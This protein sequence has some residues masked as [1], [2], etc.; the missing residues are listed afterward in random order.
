MGID[1]NHFVVVSLLVDVKVTTHR[2]RKSQ[3]LKKR[4]SRSGFEPGL[5]CLPLERLIAGLK[6]SAMKPRLL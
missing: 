6:Q 2:V 4:V 3:V 1:V 5:V